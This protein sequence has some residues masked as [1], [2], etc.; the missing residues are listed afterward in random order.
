MDSNIYSEEE[1]KKKYENVS[2]QT[3]LKTIQDKDNKQAADALEGM[4]WKTL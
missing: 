2:I 1:N 4:D 3:M